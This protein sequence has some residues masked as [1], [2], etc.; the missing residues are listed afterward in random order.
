MLQYQLSQEESQ[1][2]CQQT[3]L[4][5]LDHDMVKALLTPSVV[6]NC[7]LPDSINKSF[8]NG[9]VTTCANDCFSELISLPACGYGCPRSVPAP[10]VETQAAFHQFS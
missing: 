3:V 5:A 2:L 7:K 8:V 1:V 4:V 9:T 10:S 6:L